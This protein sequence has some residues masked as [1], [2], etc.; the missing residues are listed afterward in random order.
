MDGIPGG[1]CVCGVREVLAL[2]L[3]L[4]QLKNYG[5]VPLDGRSQVRLAL[6]WQGAQQVR[7]GSRSA[8]SIR[9]LCS[10]AV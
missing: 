9:Y 5:H 10:V 1:G 7:T 3:S 2:L 6:G 8:P 4:L